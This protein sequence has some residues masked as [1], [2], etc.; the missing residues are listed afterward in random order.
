ME[1][2]GIII[3]ELLCDNAQQIIPLALIHSS[4]IRESEL[5]LNVETVNQLSSSK[6]AQIGF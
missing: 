5:S 3:N 6:L 2:I 1:E 4:V